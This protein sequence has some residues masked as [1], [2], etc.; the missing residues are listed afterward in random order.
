METIKLEEFKQYIVKDKRINS[1]I[2]IKVISM[3]ETTILILNLDM[4][5]ANQK[6]LSKQQFESR[7]SLTEVL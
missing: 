5:N 3:T 1:F 6:R 2:R 4:Q 7:Y